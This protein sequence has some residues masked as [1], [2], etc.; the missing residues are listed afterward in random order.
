MRSDVCRAC[1]GLSLSALAV[2]ADG[3]FVVSDGRAVVEK[4]PS[5]IEHEGDRVRVRDA[6]IA[7]LCAPVLHRV[8]GSAG[9]H[10]LPEFEESQV[11]TGRAQYRIRR[12][13]LSPG[14][15]KARRT[16]VVTIDRL[17]TALPT[18]ETLQSAFGLTARESEVALLLAQRL[19]TP[20]IAARIGRSAHT[21]R[22]HVERVRT[23]LRVK[24]RAEV[25]AVITCV[26]TRN[27]Q[28][29][30]TR[31]RVSVGRMEATPRNP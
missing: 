16:I 27:R 19:T 20:E 31:P 5:L 23:K 21:A 22:H 28:Q 1:P 3:L 10:V 26:E 15:E 17:S 13:I 18:P 2:I 8:R 25:A 12:V 14:I 4:L 6:V 11:S 24:S 9:D 30:P 29:R 7:M